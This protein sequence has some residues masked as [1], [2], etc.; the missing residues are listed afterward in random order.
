M[1]MEGYN[2]GSEKIVG[3]KQNA[4]GF[5]DTSKAM[6]MIEGEK[7]ETIS[8]LAKVKDA[9]ETLIQRIGRSD[10]TDEELR[11]IKS[12]ASAVFEFDISKLFPN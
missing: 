10:L 8:H 6:T 5:L 2:N 11:G 1:G 3:A 12:R 9:I 7:A 4:D